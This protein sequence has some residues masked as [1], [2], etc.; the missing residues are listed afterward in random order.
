[1][2]YTIDQIHVGDQVQFTGR[3][4]YFTITRIDSALS[5]GSL[6]GND[7]EG[8]ERGPYTTALVKDVIPA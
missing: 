5:G 7:L 6:W 3:P 8:T 2:S 1:V 4:D